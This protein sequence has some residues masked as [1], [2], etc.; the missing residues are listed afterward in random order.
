M[1]LLSK[2]VNH[3]QV[4]YKLRRLNSIVEYPFRNVKAANCIE[5]GHNVRIKKHA[6]FSL[7]PDCK[8]KI[9]D[10][11]RIGRHLILSGVNTS[12]VIEENVLISERVLITESN[13]DFI[14]VTKPIIGMGAISGGPVRIG[15][16]S[17]IGIGVCI[18]PNVTIGKHCIIGANAVV[19][20]YI[21]DYSIA[22]GV[23]AKVTKCYDFEKQKWVV[24]P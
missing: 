6:W 2:C 11:T 4:F 13:H 21:P 18:L 17:W 1:S 19:T 22:T 8:V 24:T 20:K 9:G 15:T 16:G 7:K 10:N 5:F 12:I 3:V 14:D 23:P